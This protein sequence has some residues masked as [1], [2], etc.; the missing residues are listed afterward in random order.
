MVV[1]N[2]TKKP[3]VCIGMPTYNGEKCI[4]KAID[5]VLSQ[6]FTDFELIISDNVSE[7]STSMICKEYEK[8]DQR[9]KYIKHEI[10]RGPSFNFQFVLSESKSEY[11]V[12][13]AD[14]D[15]WE[16]TFLE[17]NVIVLESNNNVVG[18]I[19]LVK[20][21]IDN[22]CE[23]Q[24]NT[25][26]RLK[27]FL[28]GKIVNIDKYEHVHP[29]FGDYE[30]K[31]TLYLRF[32]QGSFIYGVFRTEILKKRLVLPD[33]VESWDLVIILNI[34]KDGDLNVIDEILMYRDSSGV[35]S[36]IREKSNKKI[37]QEIRTLFLFRSSLW[38]WC[39]KNI[40]FKFFI[41][42][43][44]WFILLTIYECRSILLK[45]LHR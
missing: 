7:D 14:D 42:N 28:R 5:S 44:D 9:I 8:K 18:S 32:N 11:F 40:G 12:W 15:Y 19:S 2:N 23:F 38:G 34:L 20:Y 41:K 31:A 39:I 6:T 22:E 4:K 10:N 24:K 3:K 13:L 1:L 36:A 27:K 37:L 45:I 33:S 30:K 43:I 26:Q 29:A 16:P 21:I 17:K 35:R 25:T